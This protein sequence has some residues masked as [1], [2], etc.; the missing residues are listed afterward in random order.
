M[1]TCTAQASGSVHPKALTPL[2]HRAECAEWGAGRSKNAPRLQEGCSHLSP[3]NFDDKG[4]ELREIDG[5]FAIS[6]SHGEGQVEVGGLGRRAL[7]AGQVR[8]SAQGRLEARLGQHKLART[9][10]RLAVHRRRL[11]EL[12]RHFGRLVGAEGRRRG[13]RRPLAAAGGAGRPGARGGARLGGLWAGGFGGRRAGG[14][15]GGSVAAA[16]G[17][18]G[19]WAWAPVGRVRRSVASRG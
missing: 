1:P 11:P 18:G 16:G 12:A 13:G 5:A 9:R 7:E 14:N 2:M 10:V 6:I 8:N 3:A 4:R 15:A 17:G 19:G